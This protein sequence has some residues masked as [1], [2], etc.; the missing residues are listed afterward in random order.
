MR[1]EK[2]AQRAFTLI[3]L[4][5]V[6]AIIAILAAI[7]F[8]VFA[9]ARENA[10]KSTCQSN[11]KQLA[12]GARMYAQD[13]DEMFQIGWGGG[14]AKQWW[15][16]WYP[17]VKNGQVYRCP[18]QPS[19]SN[20]NGYGMSIQ[21]TYATGCESNWPNSY[22]GVMEVNV[23]AHSEA[24]LI[25]EYVGHRTCPPWHAM[26]YHNYYNNVAWP[27][28]RITL[29]MDGANYAFFDGHVKWLRPNQTI[30]DQTGGGP[31]LWNNTG[32]Q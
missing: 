15:Y 25:G 10:R 29:H 3:E 7:L 22:G 23:K 5:V 31:N 9:R 8:P 32:R 21:L 20:Q 30:R 2:S 24:I 17:Y 14:G 18:S 28:S 19:V 16:A 4:L 11:L 6:I 26:Q 1:R 13:Y 27:H 12:L